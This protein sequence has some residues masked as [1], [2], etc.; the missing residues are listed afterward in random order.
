VQDPATI[1]IHA[2][3]AL[4]ELPDVAPAIRPATTFARAE[5]GRV[6]RRESHETTER[7][8]AVL[9]ALDG[10]HAVVYPS[11][12]AAAAALLRRLS[13]RLISLPGDVYHGVR[14]LVLQGAA[15]GAWGVSEPGGLA[16]GD[17]WWVETPSN[18]RCLVS[19]VAAV[20][21]DARSRG[22]SV[23]VDSTFATPVLLR[24]LAL[25]AEA[26]VH[27]STKFIAG[28]SDAM[29]GAVVCSDPE[30]A[31][32]LRSRR[33]VDGS[34]PGSLDTWLTLRGVRTL[35]LRV[36]RQS[37]TASAVAQWLVGRVPRVW[38]PGLADHPGHDVAAAQMAAYGGI[39]SFEVADA[40]AA[41]RVVGGLRL[42][43]VATSLGGV[44]SL[45]EHRAV[46]DP[47]A[48]PGLI[49]LSIGLEAAADLI[50][51]LEAALA[52]AAA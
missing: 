4:T 44:E 25:G 20:A 1:A 6:Y 21:S 41:R 35:P 13:P 23:V 16:A 38:Y 46:V 5:G 27:S 15:E 34:I 40:A 49:R 43:T 52:G 33:T 26:V 31:D 11:G 39:V 18:P 32:S 36:E 9:G 45:A 19:D 24:P 2:D 30:L 50:G 42:F 3:D 37:A 7:L 51:D 14:A 48:P 22:V 17:V 12:M 47:E 10:G 29:G 8:E 28:H